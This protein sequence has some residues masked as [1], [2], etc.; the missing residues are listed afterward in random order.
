MSQLSHYQQTCSFGFQTE[1]PSNPYNCSMLSQQCFIENQNNS[2]DTT[3]C[4][5]ST[6]TLDSKSC[7]PKARRDTMVKN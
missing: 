3:A 4:N 5:L 6:S 1:F 2:L 7:I